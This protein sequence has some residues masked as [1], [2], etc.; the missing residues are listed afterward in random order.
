MKT[1]V[2]IGAGSRITFQYALPLFT[3]FSDR[4]KLIGI[5]DLNRLRA[6]QLNEKLNNQCRIFSNFDEMADYEKPD[7][8]IIGTPDA[9]HHEYII[10]SLSRGIEVVCEKPITIDAEKAQAIIDAEKKYNKEI[11]V[12]FNYRFTAFATRIRKLLAEYDFGEIKTVHF[13]WHLDRQHGADYFRRWH[14]EMKN[15]GGLLVHKS[16]HHFDL[17]NWLLQ[18]EPQ[19]VFAYG[20]LEVYGRK[21]APF[22]GTTCRTCSYSTVC[23]FFIDFTKDPFVKNAYLNCEEED[24]YYRDSCVYSEVIDIYDTASVMV[25]YKKGTHL[26]Y[27]FNAYSPYEGYRLVISG[28][29]GRIEAEDF[30]GLVGYYKNQQIY[31]LRYFNLNEEKIDIHIAPQTG[32]HGGGDDNMMNMIFGNLKDDPYGHLASSRDGIMSAMIGI[33]ANKSIVTGTPQNILDLIHF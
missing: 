26:T 10:K 16:T 18:D 24:H 15:S 7:M 1:C 9:Y 20:G 13:E 14:R 21:N 25:R 32:S 33:A 2:L 22:Y 4:I 29:K 31:N 28:E 5:V 12:T 17:V 8:V 3:N 6:E 27:S 30:H 23:P 19:Q 11:R